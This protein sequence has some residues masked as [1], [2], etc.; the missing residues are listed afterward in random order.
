[1]F[2]ATFKKYH[3]LLLETKMFMTTAIEITNTCKSSIKSR[4]K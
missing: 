1:M 2:N 4:E 3:T